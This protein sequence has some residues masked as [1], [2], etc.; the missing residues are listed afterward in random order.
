MTLMK[1]N[2]NEDR[3]PDDKMTYMDNALTQSASHKDK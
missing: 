2:N 1:E 3:K